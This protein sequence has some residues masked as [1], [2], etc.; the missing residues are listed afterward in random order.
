MQRQQF[1]L[2][3]LIGGATTSKAHTAIKIEPGYQNAPTIH[4][5]DASRAVGVVSQLLSETMRGDF[6]A[7]T[8]AEYEKVRL[9]HKNKRSENEM[10]SLEEARENKHPV[11]WTGYVPP[12]PAF[13]GLKTFQRY[14]L[15]TLVAYIDWTPFFQTWE[16]AGKYPDILSDDV[17]GESA[18]HVFADAQAMLKRIIAENWLQ[19]SAVIGFFPANSRGDDIQLFNNE[20]RDSELAAF[21]MLRQQTRKP[22]DKYNLCLADYIAPADTG[23]EDY[24]GCF[25]VT[26]GIGLDEKVK[27][28]EAKH[29]DYNIILLKALA[30]RLAEAFAEHMHECVRKEFWGYAS[31][32]N[33]SNQELINEQYQ[34]IRPAPGYPACPDHTEKPLLFDLLSAEQNAGIRLTENFAMLPASAVSG[35]YFSHPE[36]RYFGIGKIGMDQARDYAQ[37]KG[38]EMELVKRWLATHLLESER[39]HEAA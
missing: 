4:V 5:V 37:R 28:F 3:L 25:A 39:D 29:D 31:V 13:T 17:V 9:R 22:K 23:I 24:L 34:G 14:P 30:D 35:F 6:I 2:P 21:R 7:A 16:L 33:F 20:K 32:E 18:R 1:N 38:M 15:E 36:S 12:K 27:E 19:A 11:N 8:K 26:T 10:I